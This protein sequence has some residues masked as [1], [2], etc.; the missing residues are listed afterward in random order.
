MSEIDCIKSAKYKNVII[1]DENNGL[2]YVD[3]K[4]RLDGTLSVSEN[5]NSSGNISLTSENSY[6]NFGSTQGSS[7]YGFRDDN[8][9][10][11]FK[12]SLGA[13]RNIGTSCGGVSASI[14]SGAQNNRITLY[15]GSE[16][17]TGSAKLTFDNRQLF[18]DAGANIGGR[19][20]VGKKLSVKG[21][22]VTDSNVS[23]AG[24]VQVVDLVVSDETHLGRFLSVSGNI[25]AT[26]NILCKNLSVSEQCNIGQNLFVKNKTIIKNGLDVTGFTNISSNLSV[27]GKT[28]IANSLTVERDVISRGNLIGKHLSVSGNTYITGIIS[29]KNF[30]IRNLDVQHNNISETLSIS[31][32]VYLHGVLS[33]SDDILSTSNISVS[34]SAYIADHLSVAEDIFATKNIRLTKSIIGRDLSISNTLVTGTNAR[35]GGNLTTVGDVDVTG[36]T[37][38]TGALSVTGNIYASGDIIGSTNSDLSVYSNAFIGGNMN[39]SKGLNVIGVTN[40]SNKL[41][42][43]GHT[44]LRNG[45]AVEGNTNLSG[46][47]SVGGNVNIVGA[48]SKGSGTFKINHPNPEKSS[49]HWLYHSFVESP[50]SGD[51]LYRYK[52]NIHDLQH[53]ILLEEYHQYLNTNYQVWLN[54]DRHFGQGYGYV[55]NNKLKLKVNKDGVYNVLLIGTRKD[56]MAI[57][58]WPGVEVKK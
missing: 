17:I 40:I 7:G 1:G 2:L 12:N 23:V 24:T 9:Y 55:E 19:L 21:D 18:V 31:K 3:G 6:I 10:I 42:V 16:T 27:G 48:L 11:K 35:I 25:R 28:N 30:N 51:N 8:G 32:N 47:L 33:T 15:S 22:I 13:W 37:S 14:T 43:D 49:T 46:K 36:V 53:N 39:I 38:L 54:P 56:N 58:N 57:K 4:E 20:N 29:T 44:N 52:V 26:R 45:L 5:I 50:T 41:N 34:N